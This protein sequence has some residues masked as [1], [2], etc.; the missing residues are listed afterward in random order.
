MAGAFD[1]MWGMLPETLQSERIKKVYTVIGKIFD[2]LEAKERP[3]V[4]TEVLSKLSGDMLDQ[5]GNSFL[6][7]R[8]QRDDESYK[9]RIEIENR[10]L[11]FVP[12]LDNFID[13]IKDIT[14]YRVDITEGWKLEK[15]QKALLDVDIVI[16]AG[17]D[18]TLLFDLDK[19]YSSGIKINWKIQQEEFYP[20]QLVGHHNNTGIRN[21]H[22]RVTRGVR[23]QRWNVF[24]LSGKHNIINKKE[25]FREKR[26]T[27][28]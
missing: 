9:R 15:P 20:W 6:V 11:S 10:K 23:T 4:Y 16:P 28:K 13:L 17:D 1:R 3:Y 2:E 22:R 7:Y 8:E 25:I 24:K 12:L 5:Y 18:P 21:L 14:G 27:D 26:K 19:I